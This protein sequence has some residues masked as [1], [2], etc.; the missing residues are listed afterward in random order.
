MLLKFPEAPS[1]KYIK[2]KAAE[3]GINIKC[4]SDYLLAPLDGIE[5]TAVINYSG[6]SPEIIKN[7]D[8]K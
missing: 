8:I 2:E 6:S 4:L 5:K 3:N 7:L 1:D